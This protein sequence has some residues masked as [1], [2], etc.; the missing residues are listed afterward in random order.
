VNCASVPRASRALH[1]NRAG[2]HSKHEQVQAMSGLFVY[3]HRATQCML[4]GRRC[5]APSRSSSGITT[6]VHHDAPHGAH[7]FMHCQT[8]IRQNASSAR[9][10]PQTLLDYSVGCKGY[11]ARSLSPGW[12]MA[13]QLVECLQPRAP[14][15]AAKHRNLQP[16]REPA[17]KMRHGDSPRRY[18]ADARSH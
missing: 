11:F 12:D 4:F 13:I 14:T 5:R 1:C 17:L 15:A 8:C 9:P 7:A 16:H 18:A 10:T 3:T 2:Q 6:F